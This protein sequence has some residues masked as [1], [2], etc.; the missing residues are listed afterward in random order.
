MQ[1]STTA[2]G[3]P[4]E[5]PLPYECGTVRYVEVH[6]YDMILD[7]IYKGTGHDV[8]QSAKQLQTTGCPF[9]HIKDWQGNLYEVVGGETGIDLLEV[10]DKDGNKFEVLPY[11]DGTED[12]DNPYGIVWQEEFF[13]RYI[14]RS[15]K[16]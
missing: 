7:F 4:F 8:L 15:M 2:E 6:I 13:N 10:V 12:P 16:K 5:S 1:T 3:Q 14:F 11:D 9:L